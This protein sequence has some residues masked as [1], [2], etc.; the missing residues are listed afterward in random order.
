[1]VPVRY[2][3]PTSWFEIGGNKIKSLAE[4]W[5]KSGVEKGDV[6]L[7][8]S[9]MTRTILEFRRKGV[10]LDA[11]TILESF[12]DALG[13]K[14][15]LVLPLFNFD[16]TKGIPFD[17][18]TTKS[19]MGALT[20]FARNYPG[21]IRT[22]HPV[23]SFVAIGYLSK[24][25][26]GVDNESAY[27]KESPFGILKRLDGK[28][29]ALDLDDQNSMTFYHHVEEVE[30]V[31]YRHFKKFS[32]EYANW[33][34]FSSVKTYKLFVRNI[35][36]GVK[37]EVNTAGEI[38]W[39]RGLYKGFRPGIESGLRIIDSTSMFNEVQSIISKGQALGTLYSIE[40]I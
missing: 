38:L 31:D 21:A 10:K 8:H 6:L 11:L 25:F 35:D 5:A 19:Q 3:C 22:G 23:Y 20:E 32:G 30:K 33:K 14:G 34:G 26:L 29:G 4:R 12:L 39:R 16:F 27:S 40:R 1:M 7:L 13:S 28:I 36:R 15:T 37:T 24:E 18:R 2:I 9:N 17:I